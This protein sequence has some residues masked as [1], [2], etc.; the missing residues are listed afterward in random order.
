MKSGDTKGTPRADW[1]AAAFWERVDSSAGEDACWPW[2]GRF[3]RGGYG[4]HIYGL[5][6]H[7]YAYQFAHGVERRGIAGLQI[8]HTCDNPPCCNPNHLWLGTAFDNMRDAVRKQRGRFDK[9]K[10]C[11]K[12]HNAWM[13]RQ[14]KR[15][16]RECRRLETPTARDRVAAAA[17]LR[18]WRAKKR[19]EQ[20]T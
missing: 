15:R 10:P 11:A 2:T 7:R 12:G 18:A 6:A 9:S 4:A 16:C 8:C 20:S 14:G 3:S 5:G 13:V 1:S 17:Y 19:M